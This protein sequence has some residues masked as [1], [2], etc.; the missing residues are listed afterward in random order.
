[1]VFRPMPRME[2]DESYIERCVLDDGSEVELRLVRPE[3]KP[4]MLAAWE[5]LS[6]ESRYRRF[7]SAKTAL[8]SEELRYLTEMDNV[9]HLAIG[10]TCRRRGETVALGV[11]R[12]IR[13]ADRPDMADAA[14]TV[15]DDAQRLGLG[16]LLLSRLVAA[17]RERGIERFSCDVLATNEAMRRLLRSLAP[18]VERSEGPMV[19]IELPLADVIPVPGRVN[20]KSLVY[21]LLALIGRG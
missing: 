10:A 21:R 11:A 1:M 18:V 20:K 12:F 14:I 6:P 4:L 2:F 5:R 15:V 16:R 13:L 17:A 7:F 9:H 3:D 19:T 8:T